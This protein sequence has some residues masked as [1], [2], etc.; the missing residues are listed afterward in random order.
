M[1]LIEKENKM[2]EK[3]NDIWKA[4]ANFKVATVEDTLVLCIVKAALAKSNNDKAEIMF[5][6]IKKSFTPVSNTNKLLN[7]WHEWKAVSLV[8][9]TLSPTRLRK[10]PLTVNLNP[11]EFDIVVE[12]AIKL[13]E[14]FNFFGNYDSSNKDSPLYDPTQVFFVVNKELEPIQQLIQV[15][16]VASIIGQSEQ[17]NDFYNQH[18]VVYGA[19]SAK[20]LNDHY[21][22]LYSCGVSTH[23]F[24]DQ[25]VTGNDSITAIATVPLRKSFAERKRLFTNLTLLTL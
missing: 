6:Q 13:R 25:D 11:I 10:S 17:N 19:N 23:W 1:N 20:E 15:A 18:F 14:Q 24:T 21:E 2:H 3:I 9:N 5:N 22:W 16:H 4:L 12:L 8:A 7:G